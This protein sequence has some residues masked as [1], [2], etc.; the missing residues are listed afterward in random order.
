MPFDLAG[1]RVQGVDVRAVIIGDAGRRIEHTVIDHHASNTGFGDISI[2]EPTAAASGQ[3]AF[4]L[5]RELGWPI[6]EAVATALWAAIVSDTGRFQYSNTSPETL[7]VAAELVELGAKPDAI[8]QELY[9]RV[10]AGYLTVA[11]RA[12][13]RAQLKGPLVWS[14]MTHEDLAAGG[15]GYEDADPLID[16]LRVTAEAEVTLLL[17][18]VDDGFKG[19]LRSRGRLDVGSVAVALGGGGH[20]NA[21]G[22]DH[23]GPPE[24]I[25]DEVLRLLGD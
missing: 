13:G 23:P 6:D 5:I 8:G 21:A 20:H 4:Q 14:M 1:H 19:S 18:E 17:K 12:M 11:S 15:I 10:P 16:Q 25:V 22:F 3:M 24:T 7:R 2:V 9:E